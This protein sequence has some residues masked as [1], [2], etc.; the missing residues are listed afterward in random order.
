LR[1]LRIHVH[2]F[3]CFRDASLT[4]KGF[5]WITVIGSNGAGKSTLVIDALTWC[6]YGRTSLTDLKGYRQDDLVKIGEREC[7]VEVEF[8]LGGDIYLVKRTYGATKKATLIDVFL[9]K[10]R[11]D[12]KVKDAE[13][14]L[15]ER[16]GLDYE[17]FVNS[18]IIRQEEMKRLIS[19]DPSRRKD[20]L[21]SLFR[22]GIYEE[23]LQKTKDNR[24]EA[25]RELEEIKNSIMGEEKLVSQEKDWKDRIQSIDSRLKELEKKKVEVENTLHDL[26]AA[27]SR[28]EEQ[29]KR[30]DVEETKSED[31]RVRVKATDEKL[32]NNRAVLLEFKEKL[33]D[34]SG[35]AGIAEKLRRDYDTATAMKDEYNNAKNQLE[36]HEQLIKIRLAQVG[37]E[38]AT[39]TEEHERLLSEKESITMDI[40]KVAGTITTSS[41]VKEHK[42]SIDRLQ[43][44]ATIFGRIDRD[45][46]VAKIS[47]NNTGKLA[48]LERIYT[49]KRRTLE[50]TRKTVDETL[51]NLVAELPKLSILETRKRDI[52]ERIGEVDKTLSEKQQTIKEETLMI[53]DI[54]NKGPMSLKNLRKLAEKESADVDRLI[55]SGY[56]PLVFDELKKKADEAITAREELAI[57]KVKIAATETTIESLTKDHDALAHESSAL[58]NALEGSKPI[59]EEYEKSRA[60]LKDTQNDYTEIEKETEGFRKQREEIENN[61]RNIAS[62]KATIADLIKKQKLLEHEIS[63]YKRLEPAFH[64]DG[65][66]S[67]ILKRIIPRVASESSSILNQLSDGRYDAVTIEEQ[68]DGKL[69]IWVKDGDQK[70][71]VHRFSGGE[72]VRIALSVRLAISKVLSELPEAGKRLSRMK[73]LIIDEGDLGSLDGEGLNSTIDIVNELTKLFGLTILISHLDAVKGWAGGN[74]VIIHRGERGGGSTIEYG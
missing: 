44:S 54:D 19:E 50:Q 49:E 8:E 26:N 20:I 33:K 35:K 17:G 47:G 52:T 46:K 55:E 2:N 64:R 16:I 67:A 70:Y 1:L 9:N 24:S 40:S 12:L 27:T 11:L 32:R 38:L 60:N 15:I 48:N 37:L 25:E 31:L 69:N 57:I 43:E 68:E 4:L 62:H 23:A 72:K 7:Y 56:D 41:L 74:Y 21:I 18:T 10:K 53:G 63:D 42:E 34:Y 36:K 22:L 5:E 66:P 45:L 6:I 14:F 58:E 29:I 3:K 71:G 28:L 59:K 73:T 65:I 13:H 61:L 39:L 51:D 30:I